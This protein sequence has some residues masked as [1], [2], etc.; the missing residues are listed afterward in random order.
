[1][2]PRS[3]KHVFYGALAKLARMYGYHAYGTSSNLVRI[4]TVVCA[5]KRSIGPFYDLIGYW[6]IIDADIIPSIDNLSSKWM[7]FYLTKIKN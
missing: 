5:A 4:T 3:M 7:D 2:I 6:D 1:M